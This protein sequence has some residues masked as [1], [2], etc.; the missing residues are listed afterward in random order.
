M[1]KSVFISQPVAWER[2][3]GQSFPLAREKYQSNTLLYTNILLAGN[4]LNSVCF[5]RLAST[6]GECQLKKGICTFKTPFFFS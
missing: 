5:N 2:S 1:L 4:S 3:I 6:Q